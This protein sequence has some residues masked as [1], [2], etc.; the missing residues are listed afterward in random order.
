M[1]IDGWEDD[2]DDS[3]F[4]GL[5]DVNFVTKVV[6]QPAIG[7]P[8]RFI[9]CPGGR[10]SL[11]GTQTYAYHGDNGVV[12]SAISLDLEKMEGM[13]QEPSAESGLLLLLGL[14]YDGSVVNPFYRGFYLLSMS[15]QYF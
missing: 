3:V 5:V 14:L 12:G 1:T 11:A 7:Y 6:L 8:V 9:L 10:G 13:I 15:V 2:D 4:G